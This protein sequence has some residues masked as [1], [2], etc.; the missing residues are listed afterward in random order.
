[1]SEKT[2]AIIQ[3]GGNE[4]HIKGLMKKRKRLKKKLHF[5]KVKYNDTFSE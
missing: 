3:K 5:K 1:L 2:Q 4:D